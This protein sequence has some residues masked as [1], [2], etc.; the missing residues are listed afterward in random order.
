MDDIRNTDRYLVDNET[1]IDLIRIAQ[2]NIDIKERLIVILKLD[3]FNRHSIL[4]TWLRDLKLQ[5]APK[6][7]TE[8]L[9]AFL[10]DRIAEK[11]LEVIKS[12]A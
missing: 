9:S 11:A 4:N 6:G 3:R 10:D 5:G 8:A 12:K 2:E 1:F 7:L